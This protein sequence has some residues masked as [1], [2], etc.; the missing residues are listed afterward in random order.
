MWWLTWRQHRTQVLITAGLLVTLGTFLLIN[1]MRTTASTAGLTDEALLAAIRGQRFSE[2]F[3]VIGWLPL[4]PALIG[5]FWGAPV[6]GK[7]FERGTHR[8]AWTQS[9]SMRRWLAVK[10]G[11]LS[12]L[13]VLGGLA[14]GAMMG[15]W[16][17]TFGPTS[18]A[19]RFGNAGLFV[20]TGVVPAAWW[21]FAFMTGVAAGA[22]FRRTL[23]A[24]A[25]TLAVVVTAVLCMF[26]FNVRAYYAPAE[27]AVVEF[28]PN[29]ETIPRNWWVQRTEY[30]DATGQPVTDLAPLV[31]CLPDTGA[32]TA[33]PGLRQVVYYQPADRY[34]RFQ[35]TEAALLAA[36]TLALGVI[37]VNRTAHSRI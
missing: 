19:D 18:Q 2:V 33:T 28:N 11:M 23:P 32:C 31:R 6:L 3:N 1:G 22:V 29:G 36:A 27:R 9:V 25:A 14:F 13:V 10:L 26:L 35:W 30:I 17:S 37:A 15:A 4:A 12:G 5:L 34:W 8:L 20:L 21:L 16:S 7:E 24:I